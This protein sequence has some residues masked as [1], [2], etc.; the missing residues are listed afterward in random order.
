MKLYRYAALLLLGVSYAATANSLCGVAKAS[1]SDGGMQIVFD[2][3]VD[4]DIL[5]TDDSGASPSRGYE[6]RRGKLKKD[7]KDV[8]GVLVT[9]GS[10][11]YL[12]EGVERSCSLLYEE[13]DGKKTLYIEELFH[14]ANHPPRITTE[15][16]DID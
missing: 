1:A 11:I 3:S 14:K 16:I 12:S 8:G 4:V 15:V 5:A 7:N 2:G 9:T 10:W 13:V 6:M